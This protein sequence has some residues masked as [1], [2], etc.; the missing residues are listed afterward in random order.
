MSGDMKSALAVVAKDIGM[1]GRGAMR[2]ILQVTCAF[3]HLI[4]VVYA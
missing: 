1:R 4:S 2:N 3:G